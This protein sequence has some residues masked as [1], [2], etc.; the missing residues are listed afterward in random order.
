M[1][2]DI[3]VRQRRQRGVKVIRCVVDHQHLDAWISRLRLMARVEL[4]SVFVDNPF[5]ARAAGQQQ[6]GGRQRQ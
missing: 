6:R 3:F 5:F 4:V 1:R 2:A